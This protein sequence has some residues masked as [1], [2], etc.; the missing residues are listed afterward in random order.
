MARPRRPDVTGIIEHVFD[1]GWAP[2]AGEPRPS[3]APLWS[4]W[5]PGPELAAALEASEP[6]DLAVDEG[7]DAAERLARSLHP[8]PLQE[9]AP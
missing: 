6:V 8:Y 5:I 3:A 4:E 2:V 9:V 1:S 7:Y